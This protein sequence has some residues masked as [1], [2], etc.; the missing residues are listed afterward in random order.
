LAGIS[1]IMLP[2][3]SGGRDWRIA[4]WL[5]DTGSPDLVVFVHGLGC[6]KRSFR[7]AWSRLEFRDC[8]LLAFD[9]PGFGRSPRPAD[10]D[11]DLAD[12]AALIAGLLDGFAL[13]RIHVVAHSMGGTAALLMPPRC[14]ARLANLVLVE[15]RLFAASCGVAAEASRGDYAG[16]AREFLPRF[17]RQVANDPRV[18]F[19]V[20]LADAAAFY[21][22]AGS[23]MK[24]SGSGEMPTRFQQ[25]PCPSWFIYGAENQHLAEVAALPPDRVVAVPDAA[26]FPMQDNP[27]SFYGALADLLGL[28]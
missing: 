10:Y 16:F 17:R 5:R 2:V 24:W 6:S 25:A 14:H 12:Q 11:Y 23:L 15:A 28:G 7:D 3:R 18:A 21:R 27:D 8:S 9:L 19:D 20:D 13:R 22:S 26:H 4:A 1:E